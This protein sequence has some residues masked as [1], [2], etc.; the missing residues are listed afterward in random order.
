MASILF[1]ECQ[2]NIMF[3]LIIGYLSRIESFYY[4]I[5]VPYYF[6]TKIWIKIP[7]VQCN[8]SDKMHQLYRIPRDLVQLWIKYFQNMQQLLILHAKLII[9]DEIEMILIFAF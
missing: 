3:D 2:I 8:D 7:I 5:F 9:C 4:A 6:L 1:V